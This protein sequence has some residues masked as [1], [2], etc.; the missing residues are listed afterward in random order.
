MSTIRRWHL[1]KFGTHLCGDLGYEQ[2]NDLMRG[3]CRHVEQPAPRRRY[4]VR[5][6]QLSQAIR[7]WLADDSK[8]SAN[9][10]AALSVAF[11]GLL[12][13]CEFSLMA[14]VVFD[15]RVHLTRADVSFR[16]YEDGTEGAVLRM[17]VAKGKPGATKTVP[18]ILQAGGT[19]LDPVKAL[20]RLFE[21]DPVPDEALASTPLFRRG[22][23]AAFTV[24]AVRGMVKSLMQ[25]LG[26]DPR[27]FGAHSLRIGGA[28]AALAADMSPSAIRAAGRWSSDVYILYT[29]ANRQAAG[30]MTSVI[31]STPFEDLERGVR[32]ADE[33]LL[34]VP[35]EQPYS[36][37]DRFVSRDMIDHALDD[38]A[39]EDDDL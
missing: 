2:L 24:V 35:A 5:T 27:R 1:R 37:V 33:E 13:G 26:E 14:G 28:T 8:Q 3:I 30:R 4:G 34:L 38:G 39:G 16:T 6:Q 12:R 18:L 36:S 31:G 20:R 9:W 21:L 22:D 11:C 25:R 23:G 19:L 17:R 32:F 7:M 15:P 10:A 29:R